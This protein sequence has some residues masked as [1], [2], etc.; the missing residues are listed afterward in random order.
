MCEYGIQSE[1][2]PLAQTAEPEADFAWAG[3]Q[4]QGRFDQLDGKRNMNEF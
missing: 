2:G 4:L 3:L 1:L